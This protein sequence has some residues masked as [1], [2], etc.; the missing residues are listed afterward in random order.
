MID[1]RLLLP[2]G[3]AWV[4]AV[5][6]VL[7]ANAVP[8]L[9]E[10][11]EQTSVVLLAAIFVLGPVWLFAPRLGR[12]RATLLRTG[13]FGLAV[14]VAAASWQ[15]LALTAQPLAGWVD[16][17]ATATVNGTING[18]AQR[19]TS[20][21]QAAW[22]AATTIQLRV[23][24]SQIGARGQVVAIG[25]PI[26][27]RI[28]GGDGVP[29][30]GTQIKV[31][32]QLAAPWLNDSA[33]QLNVNSAD[34]IEIID[35]AGPVDAVATS[36]RAGLRASVEGS[37]R[38]AAALVTGLAVGDESLQSDEIDNAMQK[39]GLSH[40]TAVSGGN[41]AIVLVVVLAIVRL[42]RLRL[43]GRIVFALI[44]LT[45]FVI[46]VRPQPSVMRAAVMGAVVLVGMLAGGRR[47][48]P[49][50]LSTAVI[51][52]I[53][54]SPGLAV[55]W[56]FALSV[57]ATAGL[58]LLSP[59]IEKWL[60]NQRWCAR[61]PPALREATSITAAAQL[62]T[63]PLLVAMGTSVGWVALPANL[64]A[65]PAVAPVTV[66]GLLAA[67]VSLISPPLASFIG[68]LASWP[69]GWI[70]QVALTCS[71]LPLAT[72][73][74]PSGWAGVA[75]LFPA[76]VIIILLRRF[77]KNRWPGGPP[78]QVIVTAISAAI[79]VISLLTFAPP[80]KHGWPP[81]GWLLVAC[82]I[83]Q[84]DALV[85]RASASAYVL[86]DA[87]PNPELIDSCL[88][89][90][91]VTTISAIVLT[92]YHADHVNGLPGVLAGRSIGAVYT[93]I[94]RDPPDEAQ[95]VDSW[96]HEVGLASQLVQL[97]EVRK[98]GDL[99]WQVLWPARVIQAGSV[100]NNASV[101]LL[102]EIAGVRILLAGDIEPEAQGA[103][104]AAN[105]NM[106]VDVVK[107]PH[108][109]S[110]YQHPRFATW[111]HGRLA[112]ISV[113][114]GNTY[115]HPAP[116]TISAWQELGALIGRTDEQGDLA[117]VTGAG[118]QLGLVGRGS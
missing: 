77:T 86:V 107:V 106:N 94:V 68:H 111:T 7:S 64:L 11:H 44:S 100:P 41:V 39:S 1:L 98:V 75:L 10:R 61:W 47:G 113:G 97:G 24:T 33:A 78:K 72:L 34:Q 57:A 17:G 37:G 18:D 80:H 112:V 115:G 83:G 114:R 25:I 43:P 32:G 40:L 74:W 31:T 35:I 15:I 46:L 9:V 99:T 52:L 54:I 76:I 13:V 70:A 12:D 96:L 56:G 3:A 4:G 50:V 63:L 58:I 5:A 23:N 87:G 51:V 28:P 116:E 53:V 16:A 71:S 14:G 110:R 55:S 30:S 92:H 109:G 69:A 65:M 8:Q 93:T 103:I 101:G 88:R 81:P 48:G 102:V 19:Q 59:L 62:A 45:Y 90:L 105:P 117:V 79:C 104:M 66:L 36:M 108:H 91:G 89:D 27:I 22:Q 73:P 21:A 6:V 49:A 118:G 84:G 2:A 67:F 29:P 95:L 26:V 38:N 85:L 60:S 42:L 82:D 20:R